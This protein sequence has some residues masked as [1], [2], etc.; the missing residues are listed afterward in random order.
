MAYHVSLTARAERDLE[1]LFGSINAAGSPAALRWFLRLQD[2]ILALAESPY[3]GKA[4]REDATAREMIY[5]RKPHFYRIVYEVVESSQVVEVL[6]VWHGRR[7][8]P[9][10]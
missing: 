3:M 5:G 7:L 8:P 9:R 1:N 6:T 2:A 4:M 10:R